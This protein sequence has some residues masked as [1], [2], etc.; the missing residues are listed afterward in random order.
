M[1]K[2]RC[3]AL[4][5]RFTVS[6]SLSSPRS[7]G[8]VDIM[9]APEDI[10]L[11]IVRLLSGKRNA[12]D[13]HRI[14]SWARF[15]S[16]G[17]EP[18]R[19][20]GHFCAHKDHR[21]QDIT[22]EKAS[23]FCYLA[24]M[25]SGFYDADILKLALKARLQIIGPAHTKKGFGLRYR[26]AVRTVDSICNKIVTADHKTLDLSA[27]FTDTEKR[28]YN[29]LRSTRAMPGPAFSQGDL[30]S[31]LADC[32][33]KEKVLEATEIDEFKKLD[34]FVAAFAVSQMHH[35][36]ID[37]GDIF[38]PAR[39]TARPTEQNF[40]AIYASWKNFS[41]SSP[42]SGVDGRIFTTTC[43]SKDW[44]D[45]ELQPIFVKILGAQ[46]LPDWDVPLELNDE[47]RLIPLR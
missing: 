5:R 15:V 24:A 42:H 7:L 8:W 31:G 10:R 28:V 45:S 36:Q 13:L 37:M 35:C 38:K 4:S 29:V 11:R 25:D 39:L 30:I 33:T 14:F 18:V 27:P 9:P 40:I 22:W 3:S 1:F 43:L 46:L 47:G 20:I 6:D 17:N 12:A 41:A 21:G 34:E 32:L 16:H 23:S 2:A 44:F 26:E 19:D